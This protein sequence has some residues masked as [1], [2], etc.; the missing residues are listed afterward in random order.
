[1]LQSLASDELS[2]EAEDIF[3]E[4]PEFKSDPE[5]SSAVLFSFFSDNSFTDEVIEFLTLFSF[6]ECKIFNAHV[7]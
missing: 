5:D 4:F 7:H 1:M 2:D 6:S 3:E